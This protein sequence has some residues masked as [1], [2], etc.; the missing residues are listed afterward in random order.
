[1]REMTA[2]PAAG[3]PAADDAR[4]LLHCRFEEQ[5]RRTPEA[6]A[7]WWNDAPV[8][9]AALDAA[10]RRVANALAERGAGEGTYVGLHMERSADYYAAMLGILKTGSAVVP[11]PPAYPAARLSEILEFSRLDAVIDAATFAAM[12]E[13]RDVPFDS[14][15]TDPDRAAVVLCSSGSTGKP[16]MIVRS[17]RSFFHRL[18]WTWQNWPY[19]KGE[20]CC[21]K[22]HMTTT[23]SLY[24]LFEPLLAG[25]PVHV[26]PDEA[27]RDVERFWDTIREKQ[28]SRLLIVPSLLQVSLDL[29]GF[30]APQIRVLVL[31]GEYVNPR[32]AARVLEA[33]PRDTKVFSIYGSTEAS[34]TLVCD[35]RERLRPGEE[36][37]LGKPISP[38][39]RA[40]VLGPSGAPV[41][42][43]ESGLLHIAGP[44]LFSGYFRNPELTASVIVRPG[45]DGAALFNTHDQ[46]KVRPDGNLQFV[47]RIDDT[48]KVRG[49]RVDLGEVERA[50]LEHREVKQAVVML[51]EGSDDRP[52][53]AFYTP[54]TVDH[55]ALLRSL[56][57]RLPPYMVPS[58]LAG[59]AA[60]PLTASG[61]AD[62]RKLLEDFTRRA[63]VPASGDALSATEAR[64]VEAWRAVLGHGEIRRDSNFF[65]VGGTSLSVF[66]AV[67]RLRDAFGLDRSRLSDQSFYLYPTPRELAAYIDA[68]SRGEAAATPAASPVAVTL[69][70]GDSARPRLFVIASSGGTL[71][72]YD[73]LAKALKTD[74]EVVGIRDPFIWGAREP[75]MGFQEWISLYVDAIRERQPDGPYTIC[76]YSSAGA[77]GYEIAQRLR[78]DGQ[79]V[80]RLILI[81]PLGIGGKVPH[82]FGFHVFAAYFGGRR[83]KLFVRIT[84]WLRHLSGIGRRIGALLHVNDYTMSREL[85][86]QRA[87]AVRSDRKVMK[88]LS[89]LFELNSGL[90]FT[91]SD[92]DFEGV[93]AEQSLEKFLAHMTAVAPDLDA[94]TVERILIQ[95]YC[96]QLP[97]THQY[98]LRIYGGCV[99]LFEPEGPQVGLLSVLFR[100]YVKNL[101]MRVL[102][103]G[104]PSERTAFVCQ[105]LARSL[106]THY[107]S[108]RD[109]IFVT[110]LAA[111]LDPLL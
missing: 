45:L 92:A 79:D 41:A 53:L 33:F 3:L 97:A 61:K 55:A 102:P 30:T 63:A 109:D 81:D 104:A 52:L 96:L 88:D 72:A 98:L 4:F 29:P 80:E 2:A 24:E 12:R 23:H 40:V 9:Y 49:F 31:M 22:S 85:F 26:L 86:E 50:I 76:A 68:L 14:A 25:V 44:A 87:A 100:P 110:R 6:V 51:G 93:Q 90:P 60:F 1:M 59:L 77:F 34:S 67:Q 7:L 32:F 70:K 15:A 89:S 69:R 62:R 42:A 19:D 36:L 21:Q 82:D 46:V 5:A 8:S 58:V 43:G 18:N 74:R 37:P 39:V 105:N 64:I 94:E 84:G 103:V 20:A 108:M 11:L 73:R 66:A 48:V 111:E 95:Y 91:M 16:K 10:A 56:R 57:D 71:G 35:V 54:D 65:E 38:D 27:V 99:D 13:R 107:R 101:R 106:R 78:Q 47:G 17:H 28:I 83:H 75:T